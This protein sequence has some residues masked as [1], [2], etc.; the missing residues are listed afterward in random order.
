MKVSTCELIERVFCQ[1]C[2]AVRMRNGRSPHAV[3]PNGHGKL[4]HQFTKRELREA[5]DAVLPEARLVGRKTFTIA[6]HPWKTFCYRD[7]VKRAM[8]GDTVGPD[9]VIAR[10]ETKAGSLYRVFMSV[11]QTTKVRKE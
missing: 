3:C 7:G 5:C 11:P 4:V 10:Y 1:Q 9:D 2:G 8:P 6:G